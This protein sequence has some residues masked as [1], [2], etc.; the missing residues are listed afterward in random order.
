MF[1][2]LEVILLVGLRKKKFIAFFI[3]E[4]EI[5]KQTQIIKEII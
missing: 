3:C 1:S 5:I 4:A 2:F